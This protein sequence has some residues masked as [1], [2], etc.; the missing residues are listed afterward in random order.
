MSE[1]EFEYHIR[2]SL[3]P[4]PESPAVLGAKFLQTLDALS[5]IDPAIFTN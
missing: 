2:A 1:L 4:K 3:R 5:R